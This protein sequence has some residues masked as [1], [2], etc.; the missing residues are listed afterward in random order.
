MF[1]C[2]FFFFF[3]P[4]RKRRIS[5]NTVYLP[6]AYLPNTFHNGP[7]VRLMFITE[8]M[9]STFAGTAAISLG[10][11]SAVSRL[12]DNM[13]SICSPA[14]DGGFVTLYRLYNIGTLYRYAHRYYHC[15]CYCHY[16]IRVRRRDEIPTSIRSVN[17]LVCEVLNI[18]RKLDNWFGGTSFRNWQFDCVHFEYITTQ[19]DGQ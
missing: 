3:P 4:T 17:H 7:T 10:F 5:T 1:F 2:L 12:F 6:T 18:P 16:Y 9:V 11:D 19:Y 15:C 8:A 13:E 14:V